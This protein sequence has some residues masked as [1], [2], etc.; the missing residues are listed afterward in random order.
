[1]TEQRKHPLRVAE[2]KLRELGVEHAPVQGFLESDDN[3]GRYVLLSDPPGVYY[4]L[5]GVDNMKGRYASAHPNVIQ[6]LFLDCPENAQQLADELG[7]RLLNVERLPTFP[8]RPENA[9]VRVM[10]A[11]LGAPF[12]HKAKPTAQSWAN[13]QHDR[14][15]FGTAPAGNA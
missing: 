15:T 8:D 6:L 13:D 3:D 11:T 7:W 5:G 2:E 12:V 14:I 1:M 9:T 10:S 4:L